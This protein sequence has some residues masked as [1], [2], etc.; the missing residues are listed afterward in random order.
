MDPSQDECRRCPLFRHRTRLPIP[1]GT[2]FAWTIG[3]FLSGAG[4]KRFGLRELAVE[5]L[6]LGSLDEHELA[7][8]IDLLNAIAEG[9][10]KAQVEINKP[11]PVKK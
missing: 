5:L 1:E 9:E 4:V 11:K 10:H 7:E 2:D 6:D 8:V 3:Q